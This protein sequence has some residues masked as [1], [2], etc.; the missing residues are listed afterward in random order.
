MTA[1]VPEQIVRAAYNVIVHAPD[2]TRPWRVRAVVQ[3]L[4]GSELLAEFSHH[5]VGVAAERVFDAIRL[6]VTARGGDVQFGG[7]SG[8]PHDGAGAEEH[9]DVA[10][11]EGLTETQVDAWCR[12]CDELLAERPAVNAHQLRNMAGEFAF[13]PGSC[14]LCQELAD[15]EVRAR[16]E[17]LAEAEKAAR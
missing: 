15:L 11:A 2:A 17:I 4:D 14:P 1:Y 12:R 9:R 10:T 7:T 3:T 5:D 16:A 8:A 13:S 6:D